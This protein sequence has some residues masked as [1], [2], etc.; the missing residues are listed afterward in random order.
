MSVDVDREENKHYIGDF[1]LYS[2][3]VIVADYD[4][5]K[6]DKEKLLRWKNLED[7]W[8]LL[9]DKPKFLK[10]IQILF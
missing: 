10:Y 3:S 8:K 1:Q 4:G 6:P 2:K 7:V 9:R 5:E